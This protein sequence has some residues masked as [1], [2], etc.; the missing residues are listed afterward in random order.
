L[1]EYKEK[2]AVLSSA[3]KCYSSQEIN[4][5]NFL[6]ESEKEK[7]QDL[8]EVSKE[9][10]IELSQLTKEIEVLNA[11]VSSLFEIIQSQEE[12]LTEY[13]NKEELA[14]LS[15]AD[16]NSSTQEIINYKLLV[17]SEKKKY[18]DLE[19]ISKKKEIEF[20]KENVILNTKV[21]SLIQEIKN[22][23]E[24]LTG[25]KNKEKLAVLS[26]ADKKN[27]SQEIINCKLLLESEK[28]KYQDLEEVS[29]KKE[30]VLT[31]ENQVLKL[32][33]NSLMQVIQSQEKQLTA[34]KNKEKLTIQSSNMTE[35]SNSS[36]EIINSKL[37]LEI[38]KKKYQGLE[39]ISKKKEIE[40]TKETEVLNTQVKSLM[41]EIQSHE[42]RLT[43]YKKREKLAILSS[44]GRSN[45]SQE[46]E[47]LNKKIEMCNKE[48]V[49]LRQSSETVVKEYKIL[50]ISLTD[51]KNWEGNQTHSLGN[52]Y[53]SIETLESKLENYEN[54]LLSVNCDLPFSVEDAV[55]INAS[56]VVNSNCNWNWQFETREDRIL[57]FSLVPIPEHNFTEEEINNFFTVFFRIFQHYSI[58]FQNL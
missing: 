46:M 25:Y 55:I 35:K 11:K 23:E 34:Y 44:A 22:Q 30:L 50:K 4:N 43:G 57:V 54:S 28:K 33:V 15:A 9:K 47:T 21:N 7:Y 32:K 16:K 49:T 1:T 51:Y 53:K 40:F 37:L 14:I 20:T 41:Q 31:K 29:K 12:E 10:E 17:E 18:Q 2:L 58:S 56:T 6:L 38:E 13:I 8:E 39:E 24:Q 48:T 27:S 26:S 5:C 19:E 42:E 3:D 45:F 52:L 36:Q